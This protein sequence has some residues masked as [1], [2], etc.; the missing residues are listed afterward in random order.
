MT[1]DSF[2]DRR[3]LDREGFGE[4]FFALRE[5]NAI[6]VLSRDNDWYLLPDIELA[7][8]AV[9][10]AAE[11]FD[12]VSAYG[13]S[14]GAYAA[15][16]LGGLAGAS[17]AIALSPQFSIDPRLVPFENRWDPDAR[18]LDYEI[19]RRLALRGFVSSADV[20]YDPADR[21]ARHVD[22]YR[23]HLEVRDVRLPDCGH[24]VTGFLAEVGLL[25]QAV[26]EAAQGTLDRAGFER[27]A[28]EMRGRAP[29]YY[30]T[31]A[32]RPGPP[33]KKLELA[34]RAYELFADDAGYVARYAQALATAGRD[35]EAMAKFDEAMGIEADHL[36]VL[37]RLCDFLASRRRL[38][39]ARAVA[40][41]L[42]RLHP[43]AAPV[44]T[45]CVM[46]SRPR[47]SDAPERLR[48]WR[49]RLSGFRAGRAASPRPAPSPPR[50]RLLAPSGAP[51][52]R[53]A[54][55]PPT[56]QSW[57]RHAAII[58]SVP[59][60]KVD[61]VLLG[62]S[63]AHQWPANEWAGRRI[64]NLGSSGDRTQ[65]C[66]WR[67]ACFDDGAIDAS[68]VVLMIGINNLMGGDDG[69]SIA[70]A[71]GDVIGE[72]RRVAP[73]AKIAVV[74]LPAF[75]PDFQFRD[76]DRKALNASL[77][78][79]PDVIVVG[80]PAHWAPYG[81]EAVCYQSDAVHFTRAGYERLTAATARVLEAP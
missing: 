9:A 68:A 73:G 48:H 11:P 66:L 32:L 74:S 79:M 15:I 25:Q 75:G 16:R 31:L 47:L 59:R 4:A 81:T 53:V 69:Q 12:R 14:M 71:I 30:A 7:L 77:A 38:P 24:P 62:D 28:L 61:I 34:R 44:E 27:E 26:M 39:A 1:F 22:L 17:T 72:S 64:L 37:T 58:G 50:E 3:T 23:E 18:R 13:S 60:S 33:Q 57:L 2:T 51:P 35:D 65:H 67:L 78:N 76:D 5:V 52:P 54:A 43:G 80:E 41:W 20:F 40:D 21:D 10:K 49:A 63:L 46:L 8:D 6:H 55:S 36:T 70:D 19:E 56:I 42:S 45:L 29:Q